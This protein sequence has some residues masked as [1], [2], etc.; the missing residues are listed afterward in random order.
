MEKTGQQGK[1]IRHLMEY[2]ALDGARAH[3][4][5]LWQQ[6]ARWQQASRETVTC[7]RLKRGRQLA[8]GA[9]PIFKIQNRIKSG[10]NLIR[11]KHYLP[12]LGKFEEKYLMIA[13]EPRNKFGY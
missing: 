2:A 11:S 1:K 7:S 6:A 9:Q 3:A 5:S 12:S 4:L 8:C 13:N 10:S